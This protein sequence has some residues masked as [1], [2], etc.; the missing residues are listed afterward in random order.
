VVIAGAL[1]GAGAWAGVLEVVGHVGHRQAVSGWASWAGL[2]YRDIAGN[3]AWLWSI[4][5][6]N[7]WDGPFRWMIAT[8]IACVAW[9]AG[10]GIVAAWYRN[11]NRQE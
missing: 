11:R 8:G 3:L 1:A 9:C 10:C 6:G 2:A 5:T 7:S 4:D